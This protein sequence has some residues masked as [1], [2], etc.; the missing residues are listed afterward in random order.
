MKIKTLLKNWQ[1]NKTNEDFA[2]Q[3]VAETQKLVNANEINTIDKQFWFKFLDV[4]HKSEFLLSLK[5]REIRIQWAE[6][7][8]KIIQQTEYSLKDLIEHRVGEHPDKILFRTG[9]IKKENKWSYIQVYTHIQ[10]IAALFYNA[11]KTA[12]NVAIFTKN[13]LDSAMTDIACLSYDIF[14]TPLNIH[15]NKKILIHIFNELKISIVV[16]DTKERLKIVKE[17]QTQVDT[18][19]YIYSTIL[20]NSDEDIKYLGKESKKLNMSE[21]KDI[22]SKRKVKKINQVATTMFTSGSTGLPKGVSF[23]IYNLVSKRFARGAALPQLGTDEVLLSFLP[24]FHTFGRFLEMLAAIYW[25]GTYVF[26][27]DSSTETLLKL[28]PLIEPTIFISIPLRWKNLYDK[29]VEETEELNEPELIKKAIIKVIGS[30]LK[31]GLS[32]AGYL[33]PKVFKFFQENNIA[34]CSGFGMTEATGGIT[35]TLPLKYQKDSVG[36]PLPGAYTRIRE[37]GELEISGHYIAKYLPDAQPHEIIPYPTNTAKDFWLRTGDIFTIDEKNHH[38]IIDRVKD[39]YKNNKGQTIAPRIIEQQ[40]NR[41]P[42][43]KNVFLVGDGKP[44]NVLLI[45]PDAKS[46]V[47]QNIQENNQKEYF[48]QIVMAANKDVAPYERVV[49]FEIIDRDFDVDKGEL[50]SKG[51][52]NRKKIEANFKS[53]IA[54]LYSSNKIQ[55]KYKDIIITIQR[56]IFRDLSILENDIVLNDK[57][58]YNRRTKKSLFIKKITEKSV[59]IGSLIYNIENSEIDLGII[60]RQ[61]KLWFGNPQLINFSPIKYGW[62][63]SLKNICDVAQ[64]PERETADTNFAEIYKT[65]DLPNSKLNKVNKLIIQTLFFDEET[66]LQTIEKLDELFITSDENITDV[67]RLRLEALANSKYERIRTYAYRILLLDNPIYNYQRPFSSFLNSGKSFINEDSINKIATSNFGQQKLQ[68]LRQRLYGYRRQLNWQISETQFLQFENVLKLLYNFTKNNFRYMPAI[69]SELAS[70]ALYKKTSRLANVAKYYLNK[71]KDDFDEYVAK[72][73]TNF[74]YEE[75]DKLIVFG[76]NVPKYEQKRILIIFHSS[77]FFHKSVMLALKEPNFDFSKIKEKGIWLVSHLSLK[78][79]LHYRISINLT[80]GKHYDLHLVVSRSHATSLQ[81]HSL[82]WFASMSGHSFG[83][84]VLPSLGC[85]DNELGVLSTQFVGGL[86]VWDKIKQYSYI[87]QGTGKNI[88]STIWRKLFITAMSVFFKALK[89]SRYNIIPGI[90]SSSNVVVPELDFKENTLIITLTGWKNYQNTLSIIKPLLQEFYEKTIAL[91]PLSRKQISITWIFDAC[92]EAL[93]EESNKFF[94][95]LLNDLEKEPLLFYGKNNFKEALEKYIEEQELKY[96]FPLIVYNAIEQFDEW[97]RI[98]PVANSLAK[99]QTI[100]EL[101]ELYKLYEYSE[102]VRYKFY[103][104]TYFKNADN[105]KEKFA[106]LLKKMEAEPNITAVQL[107]EL[108]NLQSAITDKLDKEVF[109]KMVFPTIQGKQKFHLHKIN[110]KQEEKILIKSE[111][112]D[113]KNISYICREPAEA[114]EVGRLYQLFYKEHYPKEIAESDNHLILTDNYD[115]II[116]GL[117]YKKLENNIVLLDGMV[118]IS[119][120]H[121]RRLGSKLIEDFFTRMASIGV[122]IVKAH[123]LFGNYYLKHY[124]KVDKKWGALVRFL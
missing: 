34:L 71:L 93:G 94:E 108:S 23:S 36:L 97:K 78:N 22:L 44:Y 121:G 103:R 105:I 26:V 15:F 65:K 60:I 8:F 106:Q 7:V 28:F 16:C 76:T 45:I 74:T 81:F 92:R 116:G 47:L 56:W 42:G 53:I 3:I 6:I 86:T 90:I 25:H 14:V 88:N 59:L 61:P 49:N 79:F 66:A 83:T 91:Y 85:S 120:L 29:C 48:H 95:K 33:S 122:K 51:S 19:Y 54:Q 40:F 77:F 107:L 10:E 64:L 115:R 30:K 50:T 39:I 31:F 35:M 118:I 87:H 68:S 2:N 5:N 119:A 32:A 17:M 46:E 72:K 52:F 38:R 89:I 21:V 113:K 18:P 43:I 104:E 58:L 55:L 24:L 11:V 111:I 9:T 82:Y 124:F 110:T 20:E 123:F 96:Y 112:I 73:H 114:N 12:P 41:V 13:N 101:I 75:W 117:V 70:W 80:N 57:G 69:R 37:T 109:S 1:N 63:I 102:I 99:Q 62:H 84:K 100:S 27:E 4:T 67:I 98:N